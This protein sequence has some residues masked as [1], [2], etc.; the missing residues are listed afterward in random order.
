GLLASIHGLFSGRYYGLD[1]RVTCGYPWLGLEGNHR[2]FGM[3]QERFSILAMF[4]PTRK[5]SRW[6]TIF[7]TGGTEGDR[8]VDHLLDAHNRARPAESGDSCEG[9]VKPKRGLT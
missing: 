8:I 1:R 9:K 7:P 4:F 5:K 6:G 3:I 2:D